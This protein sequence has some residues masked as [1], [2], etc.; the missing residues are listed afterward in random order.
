MATFVA[1]AYLAH[2]RLAGPKPLALELTEQQLFVARVLQRAGGQRVDPAH[3]AELLRP[4]AS[5]DLAPAARRLDA[6]ETLPQNCVAVLCDGA[7]VV[8]RPE[9][10]SSRTVSRGALL[11]GDQLAQ[12]LDADPRTTT[13]TAAAAQG[14]DPPKRRRSFSPAPLDDANVAVSST[15]ALG[16]CELLAWDLHELVAFLE[17]RRDARLCVSA[18]ISSAKLAAY[19]SLDD[20][21]V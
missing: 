20:A 4:G 15:T 7:A 8:T 21:A 6:G 12:H 16:A 10:G 13:T 5:R 11:N 2:G 19:M 1:A 14:R 9:D 18:L 17:T 3:L